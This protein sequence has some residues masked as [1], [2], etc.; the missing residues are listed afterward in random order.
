MMKKR[1]IS[2]LAVATLAGCASNDDVT[3]ACTFPDAAETAAP[4]WVCD[5]AVAGY[6]LTG[7]GYAKQ[8]P[9]GIGFMKEVAANDGRVK[10][11]QTFRTRIAATFR[12][13]VVASG[14][15]GDDTTNTLIETASRNLTEQTLS[16]AR[17]LKSRTSP[18]GALYVLVGMSDADYERTMKAALKASKNQDSELWQRFKEDEAAK[19]LEA[20]LQT[21]SQL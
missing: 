9:A 2:L 21:T 8:N 6:A 4:E 12:S 18:T 3:L 5:E 10:M 14:I 11:A 17:I 15:D 20:M 7:V 13:S 19:L 1:L 16:G